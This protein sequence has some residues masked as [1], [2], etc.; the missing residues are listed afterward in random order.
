[1]TSWVYLLN[2]PWC[3]YKVASMLISRLFRVIWCCH[4][5][6]WG[7]S[8][9]CDFAAGQVA[10]WGITHLCCRGT[11]PTAWPPTEW[12][13]MKPPVLWLVSLMHA[14]KKGH[15]FACL[16]KTK[17]VPVQNKLQSGFCLGPGSPLEVLGLKR[18]KS[19]Q[20]S[21]IWICFYLLIDASFLLYR[22]K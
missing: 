5:M 8:A 7:W 16:W 17:S 21:H 20:F 18:N 22:W 3:K 12:E 10:L 19:S 2:H 9:K 15:I 13:S 11:S 4:V 6:L 14:W 1:M